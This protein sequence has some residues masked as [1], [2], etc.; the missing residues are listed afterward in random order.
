MTD[1]SLLYKRLQDVLLFFFAVVVFNLH[2][3]FLFILFGL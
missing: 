1:C 2:V 3:T